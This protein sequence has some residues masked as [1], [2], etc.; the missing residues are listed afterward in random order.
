MT[1]DDLVSLARRVADALRDHG[2][3]PDGP[4]VAPPAAVPPALAQRAHPAIRAIWAVA[5][6][7][8]LDWY[9]ETKR[10]GDDA[11]A[12][13]LE[14][15]TPDEVTEGIDDYESILDDEAD[16]G[17]E[18]L[19][20]ARETWLT[21]TP[22]QRF[23]S[24]D[25]LALDRDGSVVLWQHDLLGAGPYY[26]GLVLGRS[27]GDFLGTWARVG[28]AEARDWRKVAQVGGSGLALDGADW[29]ELYA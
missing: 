12:G 8:E 22:F 11:V 2:I 7:V 15:M 21:W 29:T 19:E 9:D 23:A 25:C 26:H 28:F 24:G 17:S 20:L 10:L 16:S 5:A 18:H 4:R 3:E 14:L 6:S 13:S 27:L 1:G